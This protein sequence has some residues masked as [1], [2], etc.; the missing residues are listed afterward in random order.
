[1]FEQRELVGEGERAARPVEHFGQEEAFAVVVVAAERVWE[2]VDRRHA[3]F[4]P[5]SVA[6]PLARRGRKV[7]R[8]GADRLGQSL[9]RLLKLGEIVALALDEVAHPVGGRERAGARPHVL[10][11]VKAVGARKPPC[12]EVGAIESRDR[13]GDSGRILRDLGEL[14]ARNAQVAEHLVGED[15]GQARR[16]TRLGVV[17]QGAEIEVVGLGQAQQHLGGHRPL[18]ALEQVQVAG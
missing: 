2:D 13:L 9:P 6:Q 11:A 7:L 17:R 18:V 3:H 1:M 15:L 8:F 5:M 10:R 14:M 16:A 4:D 12:V